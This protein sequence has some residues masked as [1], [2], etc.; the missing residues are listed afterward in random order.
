MLQP[1]LD[2]AQEVNTAAT[3]IKSATIKIVFLIFVVFKIKRTLICLV[4][5]EELGP[6]NSKEGMRIKKWTTEIG[7]GLFVRIEKE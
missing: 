6:G 4:E 3:A 1:P 2:E 7:R 5:K